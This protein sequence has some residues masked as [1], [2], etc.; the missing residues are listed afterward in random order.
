M[1]RKQEPVSKPLILVTGSTGKTGRPVVEQL[2]E[3]GCPVRALVHRHDHRSERLEALGAE[4][5]QGDLLDL[6]SVRAAMKGVRR[7]YFCYPP[8]DRLLEATTNVAV[9][10][11][12]AGVEGVVNM[13]QITA[14]EHAPSPLTR[15]HWLAERILDWAGIGASHVN[16]TFFAEDLYLFTGQSIA[17]E[18]KMYLPFGEGRHAPVAAEDIARVVVGI[19]EDPTPHGGKRYVVTGPRNMKVAE[20][21]EIFSVELGKPIAYV[22]LPIEQWRQALSGK[23]E[24]PEFLAN[25]LAAVAK[26]HQDGVFSA[27]TDVVET[28]GGQAPQSLQDFIRTHRAKFTAEVR[29]VA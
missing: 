20:M 29:E 10:A 9:A 18:G 8:F 14:R 22:N 17:A 24:F 2:L 6:G 5:V 15:H 28:I 4:V 7:V 16:P 13:S 25:H 3:R 12:D 19:L 21:A 1:S 11:R 23:A 26:D 27:E